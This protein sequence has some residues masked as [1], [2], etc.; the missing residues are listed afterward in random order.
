M[1]AV[2]NYVPN[3]ICEASV[4]EIHGRPRE[5]RGYITD[6][7]LC[8]AAP[9][10]DSCGGDSG[11]PLI[12]EGGGDADDVLVGIVSWGYRCA[13]ENF[14]GVYARVSAHRD[15]I[16]R[17]LCSDSSVGPRRYPSWCGSVGVIPTHPPTGVPP[18]PAP[19]ET[20]RCLDVEIAFDNF[21]EEVGW[22]IQPVGGDG[23]SRSR[24]DDEDEDEDEDHSR[25]I[26][27][28][29]G[30]YRNLQVAKEKVCL[31]GGMQ[32]AGGS[33][34]KYTFAIVDKRG[35]GMMSGRQGSYAL[36]DSDSGKVLARGGGNFKLVKMEALDVGLA[37]SDATTINTDTMNDGEGVDEILESS[38]DD[39]SIMILVR[40]DVGEGE[41]DKRKRADGTTNVSNVDRSGATGRQSPAVLGGTASSMM[42]FSLVISAMMASAAALLL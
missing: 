25:T 21:P 41:E 16:V 12:V 23:S 28:V 3:A 20:P 4:G 34:T 37:S 14:P 17:E 35:D 10:R 24:A 32:A 26:T 38:E 39:A 22:S 42:V 33:A 9:G 19:T 11:G 18:T 30:Y 5:Y 8:A 36:F 31:G 13:D 7:M 27:R 1:S 40:P 15:W 6:D 29:P 2:V